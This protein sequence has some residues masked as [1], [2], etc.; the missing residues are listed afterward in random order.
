MGLAGDQARERTA[1]GRRLE[2]ADEVDP[3][4]RLEGTPEDCLMSEPPST[5]IISGGMRGGR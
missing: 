1:G 2:Y 3:G 5:R 4:S